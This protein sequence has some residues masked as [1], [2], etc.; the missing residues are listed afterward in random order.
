MS[1]LIELARRL[2]AESGRSG[3]GP[4]TASGAV[5]EDLQLINAVRDAWVE[6]ELEPRNWAW[7]RKM[8]VSPLT[9][10]VLAH[11]PVSLGI[12]DLG[13]FI[14][15]RE[16]YCPTAFLTSDPTQ[17]WDLTHLDY[18]S[19]RRKFLIG[20][21]DEGAPQFWSVAPS[22]YLLVGPASNGGY[23]VRIDYIR[24]PLRLVNDSDEPAMPSRFHELLIWRALLSVGAFD[25]APEQYGRARDK[26]DDLFDKLA[27]AQGEQITITARPLA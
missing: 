23:S 3:I 20:V 4:A 14:S 10:S 19:F 6:L 21:P 26:A 1:T 11:S 22:G 9:A 25:A 12:T 7:M 8:K 16:D 17:E 18:E 24:E 13:T 27:T 2:K 15:P 5:G